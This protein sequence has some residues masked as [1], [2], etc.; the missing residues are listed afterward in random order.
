RGGVRI[1]VSDTGP[2]IPTAHRRRLFDPFFTTRP[3]GAG[4]GLFSCQ[5][6]IQAHDGTISVRRRPRGGT[7]FTVWLPQSQSI[8]EGH[9]SSPA[10]S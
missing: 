1:C 5:R 10:K 6:I 4:L 9:H 8:S 3:D 2:G 7:Q